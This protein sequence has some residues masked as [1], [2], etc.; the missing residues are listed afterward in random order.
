MIWFVSDEHYGHTN[1]IKFCN[2]PFKDADEMR[3][4]LIKRHNSVVAPN[5]EVY[6]LGD[7]SFGKDVEQYISKLNGSH[8]LILGNHDHSC[9]R[10]FKKLEPYIS[11]QDTRVVNW[12]GFKFFLSHYSHRVWPNSHRGTFHL[13]GHSH[14]TL[15]GFGRSMDVGVDTNNFYPYSAAELTNILLKENFIGVDHHLEAFGDCKE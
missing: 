14:G 9:Y 4:V 6:H 8:H 1:I 10:K 15:P 12:E 5:D 13:Y 2:R 7:V 11:V 3:E